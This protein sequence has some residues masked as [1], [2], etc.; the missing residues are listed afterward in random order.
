MMNRRRTYFVAADGTIE[1]EEHKTV[2]EKHLSLSIP[3]C[4]LSTHNYTNI[5]ALKFLNFNWQIEPTFNRNPMIQWNNFGSSC[6][7]MIHKWFIHCFSVCSNQ[8]LRKIKNHTSPSFHSI[9]NIHK[10]GVD[11]K[12]IFV[13]TI[14]FFP[15]SLTH[16]E[17]FLT[18]GFSMFDM[19]IFRSLAIGWNLLT[20]VYFTTITLKRWEIIDTNHRHSCLYGYDS[21]KIITYHLDKKLP[22]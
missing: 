18:I 10:Q 20:L 13:L 12:V 3:L 4:V 21:S 11:R 19:D 1:R 2:V 22:E 15:L 5:Y 14:L 8:K 6:T 16:F 17:T 9:F 7:K